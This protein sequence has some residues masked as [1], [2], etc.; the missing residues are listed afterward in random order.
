MTKKQLKKKMHQ[1]AYLSAKMWTV[2][3][4]I[5]DELENLGFSSEMYR[6]GSGCSLEEL[7]AGNDI[8]E[9]LMETLFSVTE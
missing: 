7:E 6:N 1:L 5:E 8:T 9:E 2:S 3:K 4:E